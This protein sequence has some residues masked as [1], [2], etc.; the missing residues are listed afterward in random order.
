VTSL[1]VLGALVVAADI[2]LTVRGATILNPQGQ[3]GAGH[4]VKTLDGKAV[5]LADLKGKVVLVDTWATWC[6]RAA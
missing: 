1:F 2:S 6:P 4:R 3:G 5:A